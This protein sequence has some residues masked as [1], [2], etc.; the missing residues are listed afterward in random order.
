[1]KLKTHI[2]IA[3]ALIAATCSCLAE[4]DFSKWARGQTLENGSTITIPA[5]VHHAYPD[6]LPDR[7]LHISN[8]DDGDKRIVF[9]LSGLEN[10]TID[11]NGA[12]LLMH[13][14]TIPFYMQNAK[15]ITIKNL[16]IDWAHPFYGQANVVGVGDGWIDF[17]FDENS[18]TVIKDGKL[19]FINPDLAEPMHFHNINFIDPVKGEQ[20]YQS[21]DEYPVS[22]SGMHTAEQRESGIIRLVSDKFRN[23]PQIGQVAVFQYSGRTSPAISVQNSENIR[24]ENVTQYHAAAIANIFEGSHNIY[25]DKMTMTRRG[26]RWFSALNDATHFVDCGGDIHITRSLFEF[27]GDDAVNIHGIYR[28]IEKQLSDSALRLRLVHYQQFG[29]DTIQR[30]TVVALCNKQNFQ[31]VEKI[32]VAKTEW[33]EGGELCDVHFKSELPTLD[34]AN[35]V[36]MVHEEN[37]AVNITHNRV[38]NNRARG[39]LIKT[40]G[41]VR[42][43]DNYFHTPGPAI[44][45]RVDASHWYEAGP[46]EDVEIT[47]NIFDHCKFGGWARALFEID[48]TLE[49][50]TSD[51]AVMKNIRIH[52]N[53]II[54]IFKPLIVANNAENLEFF[55]N[56]ITPGT[57]Y[58][59][60]QKAPGNYMFGNGVTTGRMQE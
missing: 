46:V 30:G 43:T 45:L 51:V 36:A 32:V 3:S 24:I 20:A 37:V 55:D 12:E 11:G 41:N 7:F 52:N 25:I 1:M 29:V 15:N 50:P 5:G 57:Q 34:W 39:M 2:P 47:R 13:G 21:V 9:D 14:H 22:K 31:I 26:D 54:Q 27:Q 56:T 49:D 6:S 58:P 38:Q 48:P 53:E 42:I 59:H 60:W 33:V 28:P 8:N 35:I 23:K 40:L 17:R 16:T 4:K 19:N 18:P 10:I 44:K